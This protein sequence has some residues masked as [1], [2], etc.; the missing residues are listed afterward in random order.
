MHGAG[1]A[2]GSG[3]NLYYSLDVGLVHWVVVDTLPYIHVGPDIRA[4]MLAWLAADLARASA[5]A[6]RAAVPWIIVATHIP[7]YCSVD[8]PECNIASLASDLEPL[9][10]KHGVDLYASGHEHS[11][12][13]MWPTA[14]GIVSKRSL[15]APTAT[16]YVLTGAA[17]PPG[18]PDPF[19]PPMNFTRK[20]L[21]AW[22]Y[23]RVVVH[24]ASHLT[25]THVLNADDSVFDEWTIVQPN[26]APFAGRADADAE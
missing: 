16:V 6:Q 15:V 22:S 23:G 8:D 11:Y 17:G 21:A 13:S 26:H 25:Y 4:P 12:E 18:A 10:L 9:F 7:C 19:L 2:S 5:P 20:T 24:N 14:H 1:R 3:T